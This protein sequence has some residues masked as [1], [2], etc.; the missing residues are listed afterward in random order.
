V[1]R[2]PFAVFVVLVLAT[3]AAF[4]VTQHLKV[5]TPILAGVPSPHPAVIN[6]V[7]GRICKE[8]GGKLADHRVME[9]SFYLAQRPDDVDVYIVD[10]NGSIVR[11]LASGRH[12]GIRNRQQGTFFWRGRE[13]NGSLA[14]DGMYYIRVALVHQGRTV[15]ISNSAGPDPVTVLTRP[16][17]PVVTSVTPQ[18]IPQGSSPVT[19]NFRGSGLRGGE[20][21]IYRTDLPGGPRLVRRYGTGRI[22]QAIWDGKVGGRPAPQGVYLIGF[23]ATDAACNIG[24]FPPTLPPAPHSTPHAGV[25]VR[26]LAV[27]PPLAPVRAG[28]AALVYVDSRQQPYRWSLRAAGAGRAVAGTGRRLASGSSSGVQLSVPV[29]PGSPGLYA[30]T[31]R[32]GPHQTTVPIIASAPRPAPVLVVLPALTWQGLNPVDDDGD[33]IPNTL[34]NGG[35]VKLARPFADGLPA[36]LQDEAALLA[37]LSTNHLRYDLTTDLALLDGSG[38]VLS[39]H[40]GLVLAGSERWVPASLAASLRA[41][42]QAGGR[43]VSL[44]IDSLRRGVTL[45]GGEALHPRPAVPTDV[46]GARRGAVLTGNRDLI[47]VQS[48]GLGLFSSTGGALRGYPA[49]EPITAVAAPGKPSSSA[50]ANPSSPSIVGY[51]LGRGF[52]VDIGLVGFGRSLERNVGAQELVNRLWSVLSRR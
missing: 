52:V 42:V 13:D 17:R 46:L 6:P 34:P 31:V 18:L 41:Y 8:P 45:S 20:V 24:R 22:S 2:L 5:T 49:Y 21:L 35:P 12:L 40:A 4:F 10:R 33:G 36:G 26:Y 3:I 27:E 32:S 19:I 48:D 50:G 43:L 39:G 7:G 37:Y 16:P 15:E 11:T 25:T 38:P 30:L 28:S 44:G 23:Q 51:T 9:V 29:P 47:L 1:R 14:P